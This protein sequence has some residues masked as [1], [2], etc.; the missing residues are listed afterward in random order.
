[1]HEDKDDIFGAF[2]NDRFL[3]NIRK[4]L[5]LGRAIHAM[6][7][8]V[9]SIKSVPLSMITIAMSHQNKED[10]FQGLID[11]TMAESVTFKKN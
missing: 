9:L 4:M 11:A 5:A 7:T 3:G 2:V 1:M 6:V 8:E 10:F